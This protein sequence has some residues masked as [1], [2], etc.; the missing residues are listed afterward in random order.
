MLIVGEVMDNLRSPSMSLPF[1]VRAILPS[2]MIRS[3]VSM[4]RVSLS[5]PAVPSTLIG[6]F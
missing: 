6:R 2:M 1:T 4:S 3:I 5:G